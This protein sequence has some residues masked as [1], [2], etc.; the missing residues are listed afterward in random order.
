MGGQSRVLCRVNSR[1]AEPT[2]S[3]GPEA[4][5]RYRA[6]SGPMYLAPQCC[7]SQR[8]CFLSR[9]SYLPRGYVNDF[10]VLDSTSIAH[11]DAVIAEVSDKTR[12][13]IAAV[14][15]PPVTVPTRVCTPSWI[16]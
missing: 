13:E 14:T 7:N 6:R 9:R 16:T 15:L 2:S 5:G 8:C 3:R 4:A 1:G 11:M 12:G 10:A